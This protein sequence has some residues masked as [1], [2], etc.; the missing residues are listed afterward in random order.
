MEVESKLKGQLSETYQKT[1]DLAKSISKNRYQYF[2][3]DLNKDHIKFLK[4]ISRGYKEFKELDTKFSKT[5]SKPEVLL[6]SKT[7]ERVLPTN[8][9]RSIAKKSGKLT[10]GSLIDESYRLA[11]RTRTGKG[12]IRHLT[13]SPSPIVERLKQ[14]KLNYTEISD[15]EEKPLAYVSLLSGKTEEIELPSFKECIKGNKRIDSDS[16]MALKKI[17]NCRL[18]LDNFEKEIN[19]LEIFC[20]YNPGVYWNNDKKLL[21]KL[22][23]NAANKH[24]LIKAYN[25]KNFAGSS[26]EFM[27]LRKHKRQ[28]SKSPSKNLSIQMPEISERRS[29]S[30]LQ[31]LSKQ[32][33]FLMANCF[34]SFRKAKLEVNTKTMQILAKLKAE[35][36][37]YL[38]QKAAL[39]ISDS[40]KYRGKIHSF[41]RLEKFKKSVEKNRYSNII[42][43]KSQVKVYTKLLDYLKKY[44]GMPSQT[45][46]GFVE[47][48]KEQLEGGWS[49]SK[50]NIDEIIE[51]YNEQE[52]NELKEVIK[53]VIDDLQEGENT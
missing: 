34:D 8:K 18:R 10:L 51:I 42:K 12:G 21:L 53:I 22:S 24:T 33:G 36:P 30:T 13:P 41:Q 32:K 5:N 20:K 17:D 39:I 43:C 44:K 15:S 50:E 19:G 28:T 40:E 23:S 49:L 16:E 1:L 9:I 4:N 3:D 52:L 45:L 46:I 29:K 11:C 25:E 47:A 38:R 37:D 27:K 26:E 6:P 48:I 2:E 35:R 31:K 7:E 14:S